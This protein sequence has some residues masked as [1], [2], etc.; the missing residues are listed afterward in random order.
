MSNNPY[1]KFAESHALEMSIA[2]EVHG[3]QRPDGLANGMT[4]HFQCH[5]FHPIERGPLHR[6]EDPYKPTM[7]IWFSQ[8]SAHKAPPTL[9]SI[10]ECLA[11]DAYGYE[12]A[13][14]FEEWADDYGYDPDSR[15]AE[16]VFRA[17]QENTI[18]L[19]R[20]LSQY[21]YAALLAV[22]KEEW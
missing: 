17:V 20:Y 18:L 15:T 10:L 6:Y 2:Q 8:G 22:V 7:T 5:L 13:P 3:D 16:R 12:N 21:D 4:R 1:E 11:G 14:I 19:R 9:A